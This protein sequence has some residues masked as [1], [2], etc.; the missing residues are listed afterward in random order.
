MS[1]PVA[2]GAVI[3]GEELVCIECAVDLL[4]EGEVEQ[5]SYA[6]EVGFPD[7]YTCVEC[8]DIW[9]PEGYDYSIDH[10]Q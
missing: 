4:R 2:I 6:Y 9:M 3:N 7:G 1:K 10:G 8:C 5:V